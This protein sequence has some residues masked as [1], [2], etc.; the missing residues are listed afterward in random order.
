MATCAPRGP[1]VGMM[2]DCASS[3]VDHTPCC[4]QQGVSCIVTY[5]CIYV[6]VIGVRSMSG[7]L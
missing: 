4:R 2:W 3:R 6:L 1:T 7:L 5:T